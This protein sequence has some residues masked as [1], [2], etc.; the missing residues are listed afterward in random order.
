ML[1]ISSPS[2]RIER[3]FMLAFGFV[4]RNSKCVEWPM[5]RSRNVR[6]L[7][8]M[9]AGFSASA[10]GIELCGGGET[11]KIIPVHDATTGVNQLI[12][13][14]STKQFKFRYRFPA[15]AHIFPFRRTLLREGHGGYDPFVTKFDIVWIS[16]S[17]TI[18]EPLRS[19][20]GDI[21]LFARELNINAPIDSRVYIEHGAFEQ[22][23]A[24]PDPHYVDPVLGPQMTRSE[25][26]I[27]HIRNNATYLATLRD[28]YSSCDE[29]TNG[30]SF[31]P[32]LPSGLIGTTPNMFQGPSYLPRMIGKP[33][34]DQLINVDEAKSGDIYIFAQSINIDSKLLKP[35]VLSQ[36]TLCGPTITVPL[37]INASGLEGGRGGPG[38]ASICVDHT[39]PFDSGPFCY[40]MDGGDSGTGGRGGD[41]GNVSIHWIS[42]GSAAP[43]P[44][45]D[46]NSI[47][48]VAGGIPGDSTIWSTPAAEGPHSAKG[49]R[50]S[51]QNTGR[52][53]APPPARGKDGT[54]VDRHEKGAD[55]LTELS[56][57][58]QLKDGR[59]DYDYYGLLE[60]GTVDSNVYSTR[61]SSVITEYLAASLRE[62]EVR[63]VDDL[64]RVFANRESEK[65]GYLPVLLRNLG[66]MDVNKLPNDQAD[67]I[68]ELRQ[69]DDSDGVMTYLRYSDGLFHVSAQ[70]QVYNRMLLGRIRIDQQA[71]NL[72]LKEIN[73]NL[74]SFRSA[75]IEDIGQKRSA[76]LKQR[77]E[78]LQAALLKAEAEA[79][80]H[81]QSGG[82]FDLLQP[83][84]DLA[85]SVSA[86]AAAIA[87]DDPEAVARALQQG[88]VAFQAIGHAGDS[89]GTQ[90]NIP[91]LQQAVKQATIEYENFCSFLS[92]QR[93][94]FFSAHY[95]DTS[96]VLTARSNLNSRLTNEVLSAPDMFKVALI[97]FF[98]DPGQQR[99]GTLS[100]NLH[101]IRDFLAGFPSQEGRVTLSVIDWGCGHGKC[102]TFG[103]SK[104]TREVRSAMGR[105]TDR[106]LVPLYVIGPS[107][108]SRT[109]RLFNTPA[110]VQIIDLSGS[111][112][113]KV[114]LA[115]VLTSFAIVVILFMVLRRKRP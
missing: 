69:F 19:Y 102:R 74:R 54:F 111:S 98:E 51:F 11:G 101:G 75:V 73:E 13:C 60:L 1:D 79:R 110:S 10:A 99:E 64:V 46:L 108:S 80:K 89:D 94:T 100:F 112:S 31:F 33:A 104:H 95:K 22:M 30:Q 62:T 85:A 59:S 26:T 25:P 17:I 86:F 66:T 24:S 29:C 88:A 39:G 44:A 12:D 8:V 93:D 41:A 58:L 38:S 52:Q 28:Y 18:D 83:L 78:S 42:S 50:C 53:Y 96:E 7:I 21:I 113:S 103:P 61:F 105:G 71:A 114:W 56:R 14:T 77:I 48:S 49:D 107:E 23:S 43:N 34:P 115:I 97:G 2:I 67:L 76:D 4:K 36:Q 5:L 82:V 16:D 63:Y 35:T 72:T 55:A 84:H 109:L 37:S 27:Y 65:R 81:S 32:R 68:R 87:A 70:D 57:L 92:D 91:E 90:S 6:I 45:I 20:G 9:L 3:N 40:Q 15:A 47:V 106:R